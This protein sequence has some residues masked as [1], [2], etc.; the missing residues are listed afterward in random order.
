M[1]EKYAAC[2]YAH[3]LSYGLHLKERKIYQVQAPDIGMI[4]HQAIERFSLRIGRSGYQWRTI[5]DEIRVIWWKNVSAALY[6]N[7]IIL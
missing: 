5:P 4:F 1:L 2:A 7:I 3:F 6:W